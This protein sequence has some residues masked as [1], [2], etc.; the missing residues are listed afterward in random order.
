MGTR[1]GDFIVINLNVWLL[2]FW[3]YLQPKC[4]RVWYVGLE[5]PARWEL[6]L[7]GLSG[8]ELYCGGLSHKI[9]EGSKD[10]IRN[11]VRD[12]SCDILPKNLVSYCPCPEILSEVEFKS[13]YSSCS[14]SNCIAVY[15]GLC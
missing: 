15:P 7:M 3:K 12:H 14:T 9:S 1:N 13:K 8:W 5:K 4:R 11:G 10:S 6:R 2:G